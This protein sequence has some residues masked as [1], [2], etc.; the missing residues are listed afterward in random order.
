MKRIIQ[1]ACLLLILAACKK[2]TASLENPIDPNTV[3]IIVQATSTPNVYRFINAQIG[4]TAV[5]K[6]DLGNSSTATG[7]TVLGKYPFKGDYVVSLTVFNGITA[8]TKKVN[9]S[10]TSDNFDLDPVYGLLTGGAGAAAGKTWVLDSLS[11]GHVKL[12]NN[13]SNTPW[14]KLLK[15]GKG[16]YDDELNFKLANKEVVYKN[17]NSSYC[18]GGTIDGIAQYRLK[19]LN[20]NWGTTTSATAD[21]GDLQIAYTPNKPIQH[22]TMQVRNGKHYLQLYDGAFFFFYRGQADVIEYEITSISENEMV[23][24]H[25][26]NL[27]ASRASLLWRDVYLV[28]KKGYVRQ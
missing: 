15:T 14:N 9:L 18:H 5:A 27:P 20:A 17:N 25:Y 19:E 24:T 21:G 4:K 6:W 22:W 12:I 11:D 2:Q 26:E 8:V 7:D 1:V 23:V 3:N 28:I 13:N 16:V 10:L